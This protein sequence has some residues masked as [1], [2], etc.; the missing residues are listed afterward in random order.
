[1]RGQRGAGIKGTPAG[2]LGIEGGNRHLFP[3]LSPLASSARLLT[4][5]SRSG[6]GSLVVEV[7]RSSSDHA[8]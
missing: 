6:P 3:E 2:A 1:M 5:A 7:P 4:G 8:A